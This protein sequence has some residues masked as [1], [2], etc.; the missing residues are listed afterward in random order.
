MLLMVEEG[1][2][3]GL[4]HAILRYAK[5]SNKYMKNY[6]ENKKS[7][8]LKYSDVYNLYQW[9]LSKMLAVNNFKWVED[10]SEFEEVFIKNCN[11]GSDEVK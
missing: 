5:A 7:S 2:R 6:D 8:Y 10:I 1:M 9:A 11:E 3:G 4:C